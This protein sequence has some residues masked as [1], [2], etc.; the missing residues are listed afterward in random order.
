[1]FQD[2]WA[3]QASPPGKGCLSGIRAAAFRT[4]RKLFHNFSQIVFSLLTNRINSINVAAEM[5]NRKALS[6]AV[7]PI[8]LLKNL[9][10]RP[11]ENS[12]HIPEEQRDA[13]K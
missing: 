13:C 1:M 2:F 4:R 10:S 11:Q 5:K 12:D 6:P 3:E 9:V 7:F 8:Q